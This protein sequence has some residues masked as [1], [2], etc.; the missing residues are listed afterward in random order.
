MGLVMELEFELVLQL[1]EL[2][3]RLELALEL[4][5]SA[6]QL[7]FGLLELELVS[8]LEF[9]LVMQLVFGLVLEL[10]LELVLKFAMHW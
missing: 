7:E 2:H 8:E 1:W 6:L 4:D 10:V 9:E 3:Q 5:E